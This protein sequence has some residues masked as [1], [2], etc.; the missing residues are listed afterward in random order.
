MAGQE[1]IA[2]KCMRELD[3][4]FPTTP[5]L[6]LAKKAYKENG[7]LFSS[8][9][10]ARNKLR[11]IRGQSGERQRRDTK[12]KSQYR[13][14]AT[15]KQ[16]ED[17]PEGIT[18]LKEWKPH[19][20][21][22]KKA[23]ILSD[24]HVPYHDAT[25]VRIAL[26]H[27]IKEGCDH[28]FFN[29]D[30]ADHF[31]VSFWQNDPRQ[32]D[33][34]NE[35]Q[36][37]VEVLESCKKAFDRITIKEGNHEE[38]LIRYMQ[39]KAPELLNL[40]VLSLTQLWELERLGAELVAEKRRVMLGNLSTLHGHEFARAFASPV[41]PAR[42]MYLRCGESVLVGH[43]HQASTHQEKRP[44]S[45]KQVVCWSTGCLCDTRVEYARYNRWTIGFAIVEV[46]EGGDYEVS[47]YQILNG[48]V[49]RV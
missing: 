6:T 20:I 21:K 14:A 9:E 32:R 28:L 35:V 3:A 11:I 26:E 16:F 8:V 45:E 37:V 5:T 42:G 30:L 47:N 10:D 18:H 36:T 31:S 46:E 39:V 27:G 2:T 4:K 33:L 12:D 40:E 24:V 43:F 49:K 22:C 17:L 41:N 48:K 29:G 38:R 19:D 13:E 1:G 34:A 15:T 25:A 23:L 7:A 44:L